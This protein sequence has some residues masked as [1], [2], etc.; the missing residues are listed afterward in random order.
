MNQFILSISRI[1]NGFK[2]KEDER[3]GDYG[4]GKNTEAGGPL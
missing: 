2:Y 4:W 3:D 1:R